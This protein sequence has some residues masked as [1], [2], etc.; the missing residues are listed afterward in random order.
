MSVIVVVASDAHLPLH[1]AAFLP[2]SGPCV[3]KNMRH[4]NIS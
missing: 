2:E 4:A 1:T 3:G